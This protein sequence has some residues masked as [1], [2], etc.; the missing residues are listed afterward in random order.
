MNKD[1]FEGT[2]RSA[3]GQGEKILGQATGD[4]GDDGARLLRRCGGESAVGRWQREGRGQRR[5]RRDFLT[6]F[7]RVAR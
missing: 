2:V 1:N 6:R 3:V 4:R 5:R 7:F